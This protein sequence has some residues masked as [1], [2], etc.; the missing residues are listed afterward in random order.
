MRIAAH[1]ALYLDRFAQMI[2]NQQVP[3][4]ENLDA[5]LAQVESEE[6]TITS[7]DQVTEA[8]Q[9]GI[10]A[11]SAALDSLTPADLDKSLDSGQ[12]WSMSMTFLINLP[13]WHTT[14]HL[15]QI[16]YLQTCRNDQTI[17]TD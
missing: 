17:Y 8:F 2:A 13:A 12:G 10:R 3:A 5:W 1:A 15:G 11:V 6:R 4:V 9:S 7:R 14:L 16:D